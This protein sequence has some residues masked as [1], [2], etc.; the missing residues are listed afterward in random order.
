MDE[1]QLRTI[2]NQR[3]PHGRIAHLSEPLALLMK[4]KLGK[5][6]KQL[7]KLSEVWDEIIPQEITEH[8]ALEGYSRGVLSVLVDSA[9]HRF[10][11]RTLLDG[12][13]KRE[14]QQRFSGPIDKIRLV[15]GQFYAIDLN[16]ERRYEV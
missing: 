14:I 10:Q 9:A 7:A 4:H 3:Q 16:G 12:G 2:W 8:T 5:R 15:P 6:V 1:T 11:L 13:L